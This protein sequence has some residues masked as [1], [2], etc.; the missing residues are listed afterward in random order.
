MAGLLP[1]YRPNRSAQRI[2]FKLTKKI[3]WPEQQKL[4]LMREPPASDMQIQLGSL[5]RLADVIIIINS[6]ASNSITRQNRVKYSRPI[7]CW[8]RALFFYVI[9]KDI[10]CML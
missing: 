8:T 1:E 9:A 5:P 3:A 10:I 6:V 7:D 2:S 4:S